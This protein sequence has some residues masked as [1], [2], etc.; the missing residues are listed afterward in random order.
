[1]RIHRTHL[2]SLL[3]N[4]GMGE[5]KTLT[6]EGLAKT[7]VAMTGG[8]IAQ[9]P[10]QKPMLAKIYEAKEKGEAIEVFGEDASKK[11][12]R[13]DTENVASSPSSAAAKPEPFTTETA[14]SKKVNPPAGS[15]KPTVRVKKEKKPLASTKASL[16][17]SIE[18]KKTSSSPLPNSGENNQSPIISIPVV[19]AIEKDTPASVIPSLGVPIHLE[20]ASSHGITSSDGF[21]NGTSST[22]KSSTSKEKNSTDG[23]TKKSLEATTTNPTKA[24]T[25][26]LP[27]K[28]PKKSTPTSE[29]KASKKKEVKKA[30]KSKPLPNSSLK[31]GKKSVKGQQKKPKV[32][33]GGNG[34]KGHKKEKNQERPGIVAYMVSCLEKATQQKPID[35]INM[36]KLLVKKFPERSPDSMRCTVGQ[37]IPYKIKGSGHQIKKNEHGFWIA[38]KEERKK[39]K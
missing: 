34:T 26:P 4:L 37:Q 27:K 1:M 36:L 10:A 9:N 23:S 14:E 22:S 15:D 20:T 5:T 16:T 29:P 24:R 38:A 6:N 33:S 17:S 8:K 39:S 31:A 25:R 18:T 3:V 28:T 12:A 2:I 32:S 30:T 21:M 7:V 13:K 19:G 11:P 35:K